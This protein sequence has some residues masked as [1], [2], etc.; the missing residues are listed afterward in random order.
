[1]E[2]HDFA[3][4]R[5]LCCHHTLEKMVACVDPADPNQIVGTWADSLDALPGSRVRFRVVITNDGDVD[6]CKLRI[7]DALSPLGCVQLPFIPRPGLPGNWRIDGVPFEVTPSPNP[8]PPGGSM[9]WYFDVI[10]KPDADPAACDLTNDINVECANECDP[11]IYCF[12]DDDSATV[13]VLDVALECTKAW[14][15]TGWDLDGDCAAETVPGPLYLEVL[16]LAT[17]DGGAPIIFPAVLCAQVRVDNTGDVALDVTVTDTALVNAV[18]TTPGVTFDGTCEFGTTKP[19]PAGGFALWNCCIAIPCRAKFLE[20]ASK[21]GGT[22]ATVLENT[23]EVDGSPSGVCPGVSPETDCSANVLPPPPCGFE[24]VKDV[25]C[26]ES[27]P[28]GAEYGTYTDNL[29]VRPEACVQWR[30]AITN[31]GDGR[32]PRLEVRDEINPN[33]ALNAGCHAEFSDGTDATACVCPLADNVEKSITFAA[34]RPA[35]PWLEPGETLYIYLPTTI[36]NQDVRNDVFVDGFAE[37]CAQTPCSEN[38]PPCGSDSDFAVVDVVLPSMSC[39]KLVSVDYQ[40]DTNPGVDYGPE[41][42]LALDDVEQNLPLHLIYSFTVSNTS[43]IVPLKDVVICDPELV[44]DVLNAGGFVVTNPLDPAGCYFV[45]DLAPGASVTIESEFRF[46]T[47]ESLLKPDGLDCQDTPSDN[48]YINVATANGVGDYS[49]FCDSGPPQEVDSFC[50][51]TVSVFV[52]GCPR[53]KAWTHIWNQNEVGFSGTERCITGWDEAWLG[54]WTGGLPQGAPNSFLVQFLGTNKGRA[55]IDGMASIVCDDDDFTSIDAPLLGV[56]YRL[57]QFNFNQVSK[58]AVAGAELVGAGTQEGVLEV[59][60]LTFNINENDALGIPVQDDDDLPSIHKLP[61][62]G[63]EG[64]IAPRA[65]PEFAPGDSKPVT[66]DGELLPP[67]PYVANTTQK[68]SLLVF[69]KFEV[70]WN[71]AGDMI[72]DTVV[73]LGN[74]AN[75]DVDVMVFLVNGEPPGH[76][77]VCKTFVNNEITLTKNEPLYWS[78]FTGL[79]EGLSPVTVLGDPIPDP[80]PRNPGG[81]HIHGY[82][83][84]WAIDGDFQEI[85]WNH[86]HGSTTLIHYGYSEA[87]QYNPWAFQARTGTEGQPILAPFGQLDL[88]GIEYDMLPDKLYLDF[89]A[90]G[91]MLDSGYG[92]TVTVEDTDLTL[93]IGINTYLEP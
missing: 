12:E 73:E 17:A 35:Q 83:L 14:A 86:L 76:P 43:P 77:A 31:T 91:A 46:E 2:A 23:A 47:K 26:L 11:T 16:D 45:G 79:P 82:L 18:N 70:K 89:F 4:V 8:L 37:A 67:P 22:L 74:D 64:Y 25:V 62:A 20:L 81:Y 66:F 85:N 69:P 3:C 80:D 61:K 48:N 19:I 41:T 10:I 9:T 34:C 75:Q 1:M 24:V 93:W 32:I 59:L 6:I 60:N 21:D 92:R 13:D 30:I 65:A 29:K 7:T 68:G 72:Q 15:L 55:R 39:L 54:T 90:T 44:N 78:L 27:C 49:D 88:N 56:A 5:S 58:Y 36:G 63:L 53:T 57:L 33:L 84:V 40:H 50:S 28:N 71:A 42:H 52:A 38:P 51:A 87:W